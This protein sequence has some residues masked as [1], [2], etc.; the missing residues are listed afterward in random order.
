MCHNCE[1]HQDHGCACA[2]KCTEAS[3]ECAG[4]CCCGAGSHFQR[5]YQT[6]QEQIA[7]L[8][9]YL[10][11]LKSEVQAVEELLTDSRK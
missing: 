4:G 2:G 7:E 10:K 5:R 8:E 1:H 3:C 11:V 6:K 9:D